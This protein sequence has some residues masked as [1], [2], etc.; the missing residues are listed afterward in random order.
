MGVLNRPEKW[1]RHPYR[2]MGE[3]SERMDKGGTL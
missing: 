2:G 3:T 1:R